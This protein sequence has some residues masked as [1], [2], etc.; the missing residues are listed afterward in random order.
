MSSGSLTNTTLA[1]LA[2]FGVGSLAGVALTKAYKWWKSRH[3]GTIVEANLQGRPTRQAR[4]LTLYHSFPFRSCRCAWLINELDVSEYVKVVPIALHGTDAKDLMAYREVHPHGTLPALKLE[5]GTVLLESSAICLYLA[6]I[7]LDS[8][9][10]SLLPDPKNTSEYY[11]LV[12]SLP[13]HE[14][15]YYLL[16]TVA[17]YYSVLTTTHSLTHT[18]THTASSAMLSAQWITFSILSICN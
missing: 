3:S 14:F 6:E 13:W 2:G 17:V 1:A 11:K 12:F 18:H 4:Q 8:E 10:Q 7:F 15:N 5:D 16:F 9:G